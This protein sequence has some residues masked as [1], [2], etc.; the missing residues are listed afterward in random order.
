ML[1]RLAVLLCA[2]AL[3]VACGQ[4]DA[5]ITTAVKSKLAA[6][7][8]VKAYEIDVDTRDRVVTLTGEVETPV[9]RDQ[10]LRLARETD[11]VRSVVDQLRIGKTAATAGV[12][13]REGEVEAGAGR[14]AG[15]AADRAGAVVTDAALTSAVKAKLLADPAVA[16]LRI[17]VDTR[18]GVVT[19]TGDMASSAEADE[20]IRLARTTEGVRDV[21]NRLR[22][23]AREGAR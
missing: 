16:G 17:D 22:V 20:A 18:N 23:T 12:A 15:E 19:L 21:V 10:A 4:S 3:A 7:D 13:G 9:A 1:Q 6:D 11:G 2:S 8:M 5:G 14:T